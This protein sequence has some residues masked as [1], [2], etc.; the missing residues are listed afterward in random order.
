MSEPSLRAMRTYAQYTELFV[1]LN[2]D[3]ELMCSAAIL[4]ATRTCASSC[5]LKR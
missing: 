2:A 1:C 5:A 3:E 4:P